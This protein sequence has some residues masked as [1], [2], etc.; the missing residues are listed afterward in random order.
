MEKQSERRKVDLCNVHTFSHTHS[1]FPKGERAAF[2][3]L[4]EAR[5]AENV[6]KILISDGTKVMIMAFSSDQSTGNAD[7]ANLLHHH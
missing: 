1:H 7:A 6:E 2:L 5:M 3:W 4:S